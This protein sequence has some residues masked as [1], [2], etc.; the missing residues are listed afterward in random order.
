[1]K[2]EP[3]ALFCRSCG[4]RINMDNVQEQIKKRESGLRAV[5][6]KRIFGITRQL[7]GLFLLILVVLILVGLFLPVD[8]AVEV[9]LSK[10][11]K[12]TAY[13]KADALI[14]ASIA[15]RDES[16]TYE[17]SSAEITV[18][19]NRLL[20]LDAEG[21]DEEEE[22]GGGFALAPD[23]IS[24][25]ALRGGY[26]RMILC[27]RT[28]KDIAVYS[29]L[30]GRFEVQEGRVVFV[31]VSAR[32]GRVPMVGPLKGIVISRFSVLVEDDTLMDKLRSTIDFID[33]NNGM[34]EITV[35]PPK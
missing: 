9:N 31:P 4:K 19:A 20:G 5:N 23:R 29:T 32:C 33:V 25:K 7:V 35:K 12:R 21:I 30:V 17:F 2:N 11:E 3:G 15:R 34:V 14:S 22:D 28:F 13:N 27:S 26:A 10:E 24:V 16:R 1:A 6:Y 18:I 8:D